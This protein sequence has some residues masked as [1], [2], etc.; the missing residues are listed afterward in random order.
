MFSA[1]MQGLIGAAGIRAISDGEGKGFPFIL[2]G[3][4]PMSDCSTGTPRSGR[5]AGFLFFAPIGA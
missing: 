4:S 1:W 2:I 5:N 3:K